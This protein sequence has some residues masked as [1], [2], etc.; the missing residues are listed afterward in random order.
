V[1]ARN[2]VKREGALM[3]VEVVQHVA[4]QGVINITPFYI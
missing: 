2:V 1:F 3:V 4:G